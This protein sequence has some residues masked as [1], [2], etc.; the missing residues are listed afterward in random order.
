MREICL[1]PRLTSHVRHKAKY[2]DVLLLVEQGFSFTDGGQTVAGPAR[3]FKDFLAL[4]E[5]AEPTVLAGHA[6][7]G[8]FS[9][10]I[11]DVFHDHALASEI[12]KVGSVFAWVTSMTLPDRSGN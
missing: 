5:V 7:R 6:R 2:L 12:R 8:D 9:H 1:F 3:T 10:W 11:A 4:L